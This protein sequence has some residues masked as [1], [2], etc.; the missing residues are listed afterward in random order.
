MPKLKKS[1]DEIV[2][3]VFGESELILPEYFVMPM[4]K[5]GKYKLVNPTS[6]ERN[7]STRGKKKALKLSR[8]PVKNAVLVEDMSDPIPLELFSKKDRA[9]IRE[10]FKLIEKHKN[11]APKDVPLSKTTK[12]KERGRPE[13]LP[14]NV[15]VNKARKE[16]PKPKRG[17]PTKY[18]TEEEKKQKKREQTLASNKRKRQ[19][20]KE[21]KAK[22][23]AEAEGEGIITDAIRNVREYGVKKGLKETFVDTKHKAKAILTGNITQLSPRLKQL[24]N[25]Y[26]STKIK[27]IEIGRSPVSGLLTGALSFFSGGKFGQRQREREFDELFHLYIIFTLEDGKKMLVEKN[28]RINMELNPKKRPKTQMEAVKGF[29]ANMDLNGIMM[30]T[31]DYMGDKKFFG[32]SAKDNN[33]QDFIMGILNGNSIGDATDRQ[34]VKQD[35]KELFRDLPYLRKLSNTLTNV[36]A[37]ANVFMEG[38]DIHKLYADE[39][40]AIMNKKM[41]AVM[42]GKKMRELQDKYYY[43]SGK[44]FESDDSDMEG[45]GVKDDD[46]DIDFDDIKWGSFTKQFERYKNKNKKSSIKDLEDFAKMLLENPSKYNKTTIKRAR[47]YLNV[48]LPKKNKISTNNI[49]MVKKLTKKQMK[50]LKDETDGEGIYLSG[51]G[52]DGLYAGEGMYAGSG[53]MMCGSGMEGGAISHP[54]LDEIDGGNI[55]KKAGRWFKKAGRTINKEVLKPIDKA[56]SKGGVAEKL[57]RQAFREGVPVLTGAL[58]GLAGSLAGGPAGSLAGSYGGAKGGEELVKMS[59]VGAKKKRSSSWIDQVKAVQKRDGCSYKEALSRASKERKN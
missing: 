24:L 45:D 6:Q 17:R 58:G 36:G 34:F 50:A 16:P 18:A 47:F 43:M 14:K 37:R 20:K 41:N 21:A 52:G 53:C 2:A 56:F 59:G 44:G 15:A 38:G 57:G 8:K 4:G 12:P 32:Y 22:A 39:M 49:K 3:P 5:M 55:F 23:D 51:V 42:K 7:L 26:G 27:G 1:G 25:S 31:K 10:H 35:T 29:P 11:K 40:N 48:L 33:C 30:K 46:D 19:E 28:E 13:T 54:I 9:T